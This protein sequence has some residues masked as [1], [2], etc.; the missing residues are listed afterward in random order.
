MDIELARQ[1][2]RAAF[3]SQHELSELVPSLKDRCEPN[4]YRDFAKAIAFALHTINVALTNTLTS[5]YPELE[6]EIEE[7][8][9]KHGRYI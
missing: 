8:I 4:E 9:A 6:K 1:A 7:S 2:I 5:I 3:R